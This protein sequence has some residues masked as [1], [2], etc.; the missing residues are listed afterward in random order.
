MRF[1]VGGMR[2][3]VGDEVEV[4]SVVSSELEYTIGKVYIIMSAW[5]D[6]HQPYGLGVPDAKGLN[7]LWWYR[8]H[9]IRL[10]DKGI[11]PERIISKVI[12]VRV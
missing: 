5:D 9:D 8:E 4:V 2:F 7:G 11:N 3:K 10:Y 12:G 6:F 1:K